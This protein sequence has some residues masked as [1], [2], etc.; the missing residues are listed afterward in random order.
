MV[1]MAQMLLS[2]YQH[3]RT[4]S[5]MVSIGSLTLTVAMHFSYL[6]TIYNELAS[7]KEK[8]KEFRDYF[9]KL[10]LFRF[11]GEPISKELPSLYFEVVDDFKAWNCWQ[12]Q[13]DLALF[14]QTF[15]NSIYHDLPIFHQ[16]RQTVLGMVELS[17]MRH[18]KH[19]TITEMRVTKRILESES[20]LGGVELMYFPEYMERLHAMF[21]VKRRLKKL[22]FFI[23]RT[24][25]IKILEPWPELSVSEIPVASFLDIEPWICGLT[26]LLSTPGQRQQQIRPSPPKMVYGHFMDCLTCYCPI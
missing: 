22:L 23:G 13:Y 10:D 25:A 1:A 17:A 19:S 7:C 5:I 2:V 24:R 6:A 8:F 14:E 12:L 16:L 11:D 4:F 18:P 15:Q 26:E 20:L 21:E 3:Y 9:L